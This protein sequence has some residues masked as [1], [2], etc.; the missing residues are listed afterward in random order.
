MEYSASLF[1]RT[2]KGKRAIGLDRLLAT[3]GEYLPAEQVQE[4]GKAYEFGALAHEGQRRLSGEPY[5][6]H[7]VAVAGILAEMRMDRATI[8]AAILHD[9][10]EDTPT[11]KDQITTEFGEEVANLVDGVSKLTQIKFKTKAEAQAENF[12]KMLLAM[13]DDIRVI[14]VKLA[15]RLHNMRTVDVMPPVKR[16]RI[17]RETLD[18]YVP[19]ASRLGM[20]SFKLE[21][22]D[23]GFKAMHPTRYRVLE[24]RMKKA[25]GN[26]REVVKKITT[27]FKKALKQEGIEYFL[28]G[29]EKHLYSIYKKMRSKR[30]SLGEVLD[31][32]GFR[33]VVD[34]V[35]T[36]YRVL[37]IV[38]NVYKPV[39]GRFKDYI[40]IPK[41]NGYQS[42]HTVLFGPNGVPI[43]VQIRDEDMD[44]IAESGIAAHWL[45]KTGGASSTAPEVRA[46]EWLKG[47]LEMQK[48]TGSSL[49]FL[50]NVKVDLFPDEVYVF[51]PQGDIRQLP[52]GATAVDFAYAVH[53]DV[54][55]TCVAVKI[56][57]RLA[58][59]RT[60]LV[61]GQTVEILVAPNAKPNPAWLNFVVTAKARANIRHYLKNLRHDEAAELGRRLLDRALTSFGMKLKKLRKG[62]IQKVL[63]ELQLESFDDLLEMIGLGQRPA[64]LVARKFLPDDDADN[65]EERQEGPLFVK[66]TEGM[67]VSLGKCCHPIPGDDIVGYISTGRGL[68]IHRENCRNLGEYKNQP[69]KWIE[70]QW[71]NT[72][73]REFTAEIRVDVEN[74]RGVLA[75]VA[76]AI[77]DLGSNIEQVNVQE[78]DG[79]TSV[80]N[81]LFGVRDRKHLANIVR[82]IRS[83]PQV[84][85]ITRTRS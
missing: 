53:T 14:I 61:T 68:V 26:Q 36:C 70:V 79:P 43:E 9:V 67:V 2:S 39:P 11:A 17:A 22:E 10:L 25:K 60:P 19:I 38:H 59:L 6:S 30:L 12:R 54:G 13:V 15:D 33:I 62:D 82:T 37:G 72:G 28:D 47:V 75:T 32:Y 77:A 51:T 7:P 23:R 69:D 8:I 58:P 45:Y 65:V 66:G 34:K 18:I 40:A 71:D 64:Q 29:R 74:R 55:N 83:M 21:L 20:N 42:L 80:L 5:I 35:D 50:E 78:R 4:I 84:M 3:L 85:R 1:G 24:R 46:R 76:A 63:N 52:R 41:A 73:D 56:D 16:R 49:E 48:G 57:R 44:K 31:V 81:F 27:A